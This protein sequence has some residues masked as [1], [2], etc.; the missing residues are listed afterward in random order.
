MSYITDTSREVSPSPSRRPSSYNAEGEG[1]PWD[2]VRIAKREEGWDGTL[3]R[4][5]G[6]WIDKVGA[7]LKRE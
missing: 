5:M 1:I 6:M 2:P 3:S 7:E 4:V